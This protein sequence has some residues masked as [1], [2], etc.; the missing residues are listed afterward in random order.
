MNLKA[1]TDGGCSN[2]GGFKVGVPTIGKYG[3]VILD[4]EDNIVHEFAGRMENGATN[5]IMEVWGIT[6]LLTALENMDFETCKIYTD[7]QYC[8]LGFENHEKWFRKKKL[9]NR[10][11]WEHAISVYKRIQDKV[12]FEWIKGH[13]NDNNWNDYIDLKLQSI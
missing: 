13:Q 9:P 8:M 2:N 7:S 1:Y 3:Y 11:H 4:G 5:N 6:E 12:E 10:I